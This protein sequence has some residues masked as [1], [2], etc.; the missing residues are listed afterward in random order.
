MD[1]D[2]YCSVPYDTRSQ[3]W[4]YKLPSKPDFIVKRT[5]ASREQ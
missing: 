3:V 1:L 4:G 5:I 2:C